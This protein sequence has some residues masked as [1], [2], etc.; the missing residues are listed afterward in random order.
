MASVFGMALVVRVDG[1][2]EQ[3]SLVV[4]SLEYIGPSP[5]VYVGPLA[6]C[7]PEL[8]KGVAAL[9]TPIPSSPLPP[10]D[11]CESVHYT[12]PPLQC[13]TQYVTQ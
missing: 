1:N 4:T 8:F 2:L 5:L 7:R 6:N 12:A 9:V 3:Q 11:G 13:T 10:A